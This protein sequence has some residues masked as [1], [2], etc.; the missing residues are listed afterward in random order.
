[1]VSESGFE[2]VRG[3]ADVR[4]VRFVVIGAGYCGL[5]YHRFLDF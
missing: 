3:E 1:M 5:V 4:F 2:G